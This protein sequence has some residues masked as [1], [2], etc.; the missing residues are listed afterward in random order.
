MVW[1]RIKTWRR[2]WFVRSSVGD[3]RVN[4]AIEFVVSTVPVQ[5]VV[6]PFIAD[7]FLRKLF[8]ERTRRACKIFL[9]RVDQGAARFHSG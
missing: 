8:G 3:Q 4:R 7:Q 5:T 2:A 1:D 6:S 9:L